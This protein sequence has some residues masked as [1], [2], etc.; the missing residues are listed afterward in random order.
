MNKKVS[1]EDILMVFVGVME[2]RG[3]NRKLVRLDVD[4]GMLER[5]N[6]AKGSN[7]DLEQLHRIADRC[8]A[9]EWLE[10]TTISAG[11]YGDLSLTTT[12]LGI[13]RSRQRKEEANTNRS[14]LKKLSDYI[15]NH[16]G[17]FM[18]LGAVVA[19]SGL[20]LKL[21]AG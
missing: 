1:E 21:F 8:L 13:V 6:R 7:I 10:H 19:I 20:L 12:G 17:F 9:N 4:I 3:E 15:E 16:K 18:L 14:W 11:K 2:A 5:I